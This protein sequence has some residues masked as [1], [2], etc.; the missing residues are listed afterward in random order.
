[1][2][3][4]V[5]V[6]SSST[7]AASALARRLAAQG[8]RVAMLVATHR[9]QLP[10]LARDVVA[11]GSPEVLAV[12]CDLIDTHAVAAAAA[13]I[14]RELGPIDRRVNAKLSDVSTVTATRAALQCMAPR[15]RGTIV[16]V[17]ISPT[18]RIYTDAIRAELRAAGSNIRI[19]SVRRYPFRRV[20]AGLLAAAAG[21]GVVLLRRVVR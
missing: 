4:I 20:G 1:M 17:D 5:V 10:E 18:A 3:E 16:Q 12:P 7:D 8:A 14:E 19:D 13:R 21:L 9:V 2:D 6:A 15:D 11:A